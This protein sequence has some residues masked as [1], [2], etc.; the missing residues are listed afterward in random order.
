M[1]DLSKALMPFSKAAS[2]SVRVAMA[3]VEDSMA[4][5]ASVIVCSR[6]FLRSS[7][8]SS[9]MPQ[10]SFLSSSSDCSFFKT[11][12]ILSIIFTT[13]S[14][15][16]ADLLPESASVI[17]SKLTWSWLTDAR[18][19]VAI[20]SRARSRILDA[21]FSI[22][23]KLEPALGNVFLKRSSASSSFRIL[24]VSA[25]A[26]SSSARVFERSSHSDVL[27]LQLESSSFKYFWSARRAASVS[28]RSC[29]F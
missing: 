17:K 2:S 16:P 6:P 1:T 5:S 4:F 29:C 25:M 28:S 15:C 11:S 3:S 18:L 13:L 23:T 9:W 26:T 12:N 20:T 8:E 10:Y 21:V 19:A 27:V 14:N 7:A 24:M 22:C